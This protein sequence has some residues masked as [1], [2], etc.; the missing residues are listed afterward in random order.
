VVISALEL[1]S[2]SHADYLCR[3]FRQRFPGLKIVVGVW[4]SQADPDEMQRALRTAGADDVVAGLGAAVER[5]RQHAPFG[6]E[7]AISAAGAPQR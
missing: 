6:A 3:R 1:R 4:G 5:V 7:P 2:E